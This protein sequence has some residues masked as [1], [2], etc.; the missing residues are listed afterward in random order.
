MK[1]TD[2]KQLRKQVEERYKQAIERAEKERIEGLAAIDT[3]WKMLHVPRRKR[4]EKTTSQQKGE[5]SVESSVNSKPPPTT[6]SCVYGTLIATVRKSLALVPE[7]FIYRNVIAAMKQTS[8]STFNSSSVSNCLKRLAKEG[9]IEVIK[10]G[11]G[12]TPSKYRLVKNV[13]T[14]NDIKT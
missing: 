7:E 10:Q 13:K 1:R 2:Y 14:A 6:P 12:K 9:V 4:S 3:V 5:L 11:H 8:G